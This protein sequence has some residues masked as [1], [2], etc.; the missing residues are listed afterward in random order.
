[1]SLVA[2]SDIENLKTDKE[3]VV[4]IEDVVT[5]DWNDPRETRNAKNW[6]LGKRIFHTAI[7]C[8]ISFVV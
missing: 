6:P 5:I 1:M 8:I 7:P 3:N 2:A 4:A